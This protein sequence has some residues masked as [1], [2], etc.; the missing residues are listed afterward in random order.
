MYHFVISVCTSNNYA[1]EFSE[2]IGMMLTQ[3]RSHLSFSYI[4]PFCIEKT[5]VE[6]LLDAIRI[7]YRLSEDGYRRYYTNTLR[8]KLSRFLY[9]Q[10]SRKLKQ[11]VVLHEQQQQSSQQPRATTVSSTPTTQSSF[12][13]TQDIHNSYTYG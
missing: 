7:K 1:I 3:S 13:A 10:G 9:D 8:V 12:T 4:A 11:K 2:N 6:F 5:V